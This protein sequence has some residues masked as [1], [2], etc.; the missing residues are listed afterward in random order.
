MPDLIPIQAL[1]EEERLVVS[2]RIWG[3]APLCLRASRQGGW[4]VLAKGEWGA[5]VEVKE[6]GKGS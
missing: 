3:V 1:M 4:M 5:K 6:L 2:E